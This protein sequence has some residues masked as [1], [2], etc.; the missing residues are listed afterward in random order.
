MNKLLSLQS[1]LQAHKYLD[2]NELHPDLCIRVYNASKNLDLKELKNICNEIE[3]NKKLASGMTL[4]NLNNLTKSAET[5][6]ALPE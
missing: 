1:M 2:S 3:K 6:F 4:R 5:L